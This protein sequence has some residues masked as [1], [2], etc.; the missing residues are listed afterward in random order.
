MQ[1]RRTVLKT[2]SGVATVAIAGCTGI[3]GNE[4]DPAG[5]TDLLADT[6][7]ETEAVEIKKPNVLTAIEEYDRSEFEAS[8]FDI[9]PDEFEYIINVTVEQSGEQGTGYGILI[10]PVGLSDIKAELGNQQ[11]MTEGETVN[12][13]QTLKVGSDQT[14][15]YG[16]SGEAVVVGT[17]RDLYET[18]T[19]TVA[20]DGTRLIE[21]NAAFDTLAGVVG[22]V[23]VARFNF[24]SVRFTTGFSKSPV[25]G[26]FGFEIEDENSEYTA[27]TIFETASAARENESL[28]GDRMIERTPGLDSVETEVNGRTVIVTGTVPTSEL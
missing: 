22:D 26:G 1:S 5:Y 24:G 23:P 9:N 14:T 27:A 12:G 16:T 15:Y 19:E 11:E 3:F 13:F 25:A 7:L 17:S 28:F 21:A 8:A 18:A 2:T 6:E 10:A 20:G 4:A